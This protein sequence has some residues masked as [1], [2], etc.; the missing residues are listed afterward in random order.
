[1]HFGLRPVLHHVVEYLRFEIL[2]L[3]VMQDR[4]IGFNATGAGGITTDLYCVDTWGLVCLRS[5]PATPNQQVPVLML[6]LQRG[7]CDGVRGFGSFRIC[8]PERGGS[9]EQ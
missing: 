6:N 4:G 1:M 3:G 8:V 9:R 2:S 5:F 7:T